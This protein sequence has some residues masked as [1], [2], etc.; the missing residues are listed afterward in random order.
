MNKTS[1]DI[2]IKEVKEFF[3]IQRTVPEHAK[4]NGIRVLKKVAQKMLLNDE[5]IIIDGKVKWFNIRPIGL[6]VCE[7]TLNDVK[8]TQTV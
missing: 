8:T 2:D 1:I 3:F 4:R 7:I 6:D 5:S